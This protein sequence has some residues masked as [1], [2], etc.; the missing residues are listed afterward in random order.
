MRQVFFLQHTSDHVQNGPILPF[1]NTVLLRCIPRCKLLLYAILSA[2]TQKVFGDL[3]STSIC[4]KHL[5]IIPTLLLNKSFE[6]VEFL[7]HFTLLFQHIH[8]CIS[9]VIINE[10]QNIFVSR[11]RRCLHRSTYIRVNNFQG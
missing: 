6:V 9:G 11:K 3:L 10:C 2:E 4:S 7:K 1:C 8:P 5:D